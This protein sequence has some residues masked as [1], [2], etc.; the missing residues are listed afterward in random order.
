MVFSVRLQALELG[1]ALPVW[2]GDIARRRTLVVSRIAVCLSSTTKLCRS[3]RYHVS[4]ARHG[5]VCEVAVLGVTT[6]EEQVRN[7]EVDGDVSESFR[8]K[9][10]RFTKYSVEQLGP[11]RR[12]QQS[13]RFHG[14]FYTGPDRENRRSVLLYR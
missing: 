7:L 4:V 10:L 3:R 8:N 14:Q 9:R 6:V 2:G 11:H 5:S 1:H 13:C 12:P